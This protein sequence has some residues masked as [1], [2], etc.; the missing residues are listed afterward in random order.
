MHRSTKLAPLALGLLLLPVL[1]AAAGPCRSSEGVNAPFG[2][3]PIPT[4][5]PTQNCLVSFKGY[6]WWTSYQY[7]G[8]TTGF[9]N[10]GLKTAFAPDHVWVDGEGMHLEIAEEDLGGG[11]EAAGAEAVL[12]QDSSGAFVNPGYGDYL[13]ATK[14][15]TAASWADLDPNA[16]VGLFTYQ[17]TAAAGTGNAYREI[18]MAEITRWGWNGTGKCPFAG[19]YAAEC[20]GNAQFTLQT[21]NSPIIHRYRIPPG[22]KAITVVMHWHGAHKPIMYFEYDGAYSFADLPSVPNQVWTTPANLDPDVPNAACQLFHVNLWNGNFLAT[23][24][25]YNPP[26]RVLPYQVLVTNFEFKPFN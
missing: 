18:D 1:A 10:F 16:V 14:T 13:V 22:V 3:D 2:L 7:W 25:G 20:T 12:M 19:A 24:D 8:G 15:V 26:P 4:K 17:R 23:A 21:S 11:V 9:Y 5:C 6:K